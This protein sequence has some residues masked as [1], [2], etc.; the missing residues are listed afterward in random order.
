MCINQNICMN[1][2]QSNGQGLIL[3]MFLSFHKSQILSKLVENNIFF[4]VSLYVFWLLTYLG[5]K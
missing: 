1:D 5:K 2:W 4:T 3:S